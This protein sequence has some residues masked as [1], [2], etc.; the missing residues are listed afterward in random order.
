MLNFGVVFF[1]KLYDMGLSVTKWVNMI[2][3]IIKKY[4]PFI[5]NYSMFSTHNSFQTAFIF[6]LYIY[7]YIKKKFPRP[8]LKINIRIIILLVNNEYH[9]FVFHFLI[10]SVVE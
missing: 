8:I 4:S 2:I 9:F 10:S 3:I 1:L 6:S 7:C 5:V